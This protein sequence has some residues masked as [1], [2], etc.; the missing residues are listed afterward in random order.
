[1]TERK[2]PATHAELASELE[3]LRDEVAELSAS[4]K[5]LVTAWENATFLVATIK[6][7]GGA[8]MTVSAFWYILTHFGQAK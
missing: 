2:R 3:E 4:I 7:L 1:M 6:W 8:F 5:G